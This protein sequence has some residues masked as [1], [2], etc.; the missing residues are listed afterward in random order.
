MQSQERLRRRPIKIVAFVDWNSQVFAAKRSR[1]EESTV[2]RIL[3]HVLRSIKNSL[4]NFISDFRFEVHLRLYGGWHKGFE[5]MP[6]R[7][8]LARVTDDF[9]YGIYVHPNIVIR[10]LE[11]GDTALGALE[12]RKVMST[13]SHFPATCRDYGQGKLGE[14]MVDTAL[15]S[16]LIYCSVNGEDDSWL[17][18]VGEDI[19]LMPGV[20]TAEG[21]LRSSRRKIAYLR[22]R[23][24]NYLNCADIYKFN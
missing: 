7:R 24:D 19:D 13:N 3:E 8:E 22:S 16:D 11:Y 20:Y 1:S 12:R 15:V 2:Q 9:L 4:A 6:Q 17:T 21:F 5:P 18:V 10:G 14:K 23:K